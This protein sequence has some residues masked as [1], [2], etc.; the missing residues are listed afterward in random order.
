MEPI[1]VE[2]P[3]HIRKV[4][5]SAKQRPVYFEWN[6]LSIKGKRA[7]LH[8]KYFKDKNDIQKDVKIEHLKDHFYIGRFEN[9][10]LKYVTRKSEELP[11]ASDLLRTKHKYRLV[12]YNEDSMSGSKYDL[13]LCNPNVVNT[14]KFHLIRG[15]DFYNS[16]IR[17]HSRGAIMDAIKECFT[18]YLVNLPVISEY[19]VKIEC[20]IH[21]TIKNVYDGAKE[22]LGLPWDID[23]YAYPYMKAFP[24]LMQKL[25]KIKNDDRLH[26][27]SPPSPIFVPIE[28]HNE[29]KLVF[30]ITKDDRDVINNNKIYQ[31][32]HSPGLNSELFCL[33]IKKEQFK[34]EDF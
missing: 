19:P 1:I 31:D 32:F 13:L 16:K 34:N 14:P 12:T 29:R 8:V 24:D 27:T 15:Q 9:N 2:I 30:I 22:G 4:Q 7:K 28:N 20:Q 10:K 3:Q 33:T 25:G 18:P 5:F 23:N 21:D 17:E 26:L 11:S 6:G